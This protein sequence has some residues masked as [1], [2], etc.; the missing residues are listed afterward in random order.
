[1]RLKKLRTPGFARVRFRISLTTWVSSKYI[2]C[3]LILLACEI[4][5]G[6]D[7]GDYRQCLGKRLAPGPRKRRFQDRTVLRLGTAAMAQRA[8]F[9]RLDNRMIKITHNQVCHCS[10]PNY[11]TL[12]S[13]LAFAWPIEQSIGHGLLFHLPIAESIS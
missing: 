7:V 9:Q 5:I 3:A 2:G 10:I 4:L 13:L 6:P 1:M 12:L 11:V 8:L